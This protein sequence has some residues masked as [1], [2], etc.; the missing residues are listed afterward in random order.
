MSEQAPT[1][2]GKRMAFVAWIIGI[3]LLTQFFGF[4]ESKASNPNSRPDSYTKDGMIEVR[5]LQNRR[6]HYRVTGQINGKSADFMVDTGATDV[7]I[8]SALADR[9]QLVGTGQGLG[10][11]ANGYVALEKTLIPEIRIGEITLYNVR[12]S[13]NPGMAAEQPILLGMSALSELELSQQ[14]GVL[15][16]TQRR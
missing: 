4:W 6:G 11:T 14:Q 1:A 10:L 3:A 7:V 2:I 9:Y 5:L 12:A 13:L 16:L 15:S 8:P